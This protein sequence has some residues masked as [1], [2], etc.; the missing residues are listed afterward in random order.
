MKDKNKYCKISEVKVDPKFSNFIAIIILFGLVIVLQ[1]ITQIYSGSENLANDDHWK[2]YPCLLGLIIIHEGLHAL[3][4]ICTG[5]ANF[6]D[7]K[8]GWKL[9]G[10]YCHISTLMTV[11]AYRLFLLLP[12]IVTTPFGLILIIME[13]SE[14][15]VF[16]TAIAISG[17]TADLWMFMKLRSFK[18]NLLVRDHPS[19]TAFELFSPD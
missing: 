9:I 19:Q 7:I 12:F 18:K 13:P 2:F 17:C 4:A 16:L 14:W 1:K 15:L 5:K 11:K 3:A 10:P 8:F 6:R